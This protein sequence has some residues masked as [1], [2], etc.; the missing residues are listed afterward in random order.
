MWKNIVEPDKPQTTM[1][2]TRISWWIPKAPNTYSGY[3]PLTAFPLKWV[4]R[5]RHSVTLYAHRLSCWAI[6]L[7]IVRYIVLGGK[8]WQTTPKNLPR[9]QRTRAVPVAW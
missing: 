1:C 2:Q 8:Q 4:I 6:W 5:T 3:A 7:T 9:M